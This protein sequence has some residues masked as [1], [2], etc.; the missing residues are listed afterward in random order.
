MK[1]KAISVLARSY[2]IFMVVIL[3]SVALSSCN[4][5]DKDEAVEYNEVY[6]FGNWFSEEGAKYWFNEEG[7]GM[8]RSGDVGGSFNYTVDV[9]SI[10]MHVTY[11]SDTYHTIWKN[12][13]EASYNPEKD[14]LNIN[15]VFFYREGKVPKKDETQTEPVD[16]CA[17]ADAVAGK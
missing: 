1:R 14:V 10:H 7:R 13:I 4:D 5:S 15:G 8:L 17:T 9:T 16:T 3:T 11:W 6:Y 12:D 2:A